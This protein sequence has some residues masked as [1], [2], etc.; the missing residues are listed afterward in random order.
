MRSLEEIKSEAYHSIALYSMLAG[1]PRLL[2][3]P[4][5]IDSALAGDEKLLKDDL[6]D[7]MVTCVSDIPHVLFMILDQ[8]GEHSKFKSECNKNLEAISKLEDKVEIKNKSIEIINEILKKMHQ[9]P[10]SKLFENYIG[11]KND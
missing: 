2:K 5:A 4:D 10:V 1:V 8:T 7:L 6:E 3:I 11:S 9:P